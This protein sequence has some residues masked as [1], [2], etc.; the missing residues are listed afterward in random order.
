MEFEPFYI[1][2][3][4]KTDAKQLHFIKRGKYK[5]YTPRM[6]SVSLEEL[7]NYYKTN[8]SEIMFK[9]NSQEEKHSDWYMKKMR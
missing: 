5:F 8:N 2:D 7:A 9:I 4:N 1:I 6:C 3:N